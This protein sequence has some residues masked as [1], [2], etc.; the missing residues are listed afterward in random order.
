MSAD[1]GFA[2]FPEL[3]TER[4]RLREVQIGD[5][6]AIHAFRADPNVTT[7]YG[8]EPAASINETR[9]W[10]EKRIADFGRR[11]SIVWVITSHESELAIGSCC[12]WHF[13]ETFRI[14]EVGYE[15]AHSHWGAGLASEAVTAVLRF[16]F[17]RLE[18]HR[19][20]ACLLERNE[21]SKR[22]LLK[23]GFRLEGKLRD[24][25]FFRGRYEDLLYY[26]L[27][28]DDWLNVRPVYPRA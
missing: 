5:A 21:A 27:L 25:V 26:G 8:K 3:A 12:L 1:D 9:D 13:D 20:E 17:D 11:D 14:A 15:L 24:R 2:R 16:G 6:E 4:L 28:R 7:A 18:L 19:I 22:L 23:L 10:V